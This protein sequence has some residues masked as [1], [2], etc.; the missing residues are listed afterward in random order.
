MES[1][2]FLTIQEAY[3]MLHADIP[4]FLVSVADQSFTYLQCAL[5]VFE[6]DFNVGASYPQI[7][8]G[9]LFHHLSTQNNSL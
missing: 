2:L 1:S 9:F 5:V 8:T 6:F 4:S 3:V 7:L